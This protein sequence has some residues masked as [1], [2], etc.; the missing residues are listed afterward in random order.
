MKNYPY[1]YLFIGVR[2]NNPMVTYFL[3]EVWYQHNP[4]VE[5]LDKDLDDFVYE[6]GAVYNHENGTNI[7]DFKGVAAILEED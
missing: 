3:K 4:T 7:K 6:E 5:E 1:G 2:K